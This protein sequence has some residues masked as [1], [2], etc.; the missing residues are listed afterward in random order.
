MPIKLDD[1]NPSVALN[2]LLYE[3]LGKFV[4]NEGND[5]DSLFRFPL[6]VKKIDMTIASDTKQATGISIFSKIDFLCLDETKDM[7]GHAS[8]C[9]SRDPPHS[10]SFPPMLKAVTFWNIPFIRT[11]PLRWLNDKSSCSRKCRSPSND[12]IGPVKLLCENLRTS[13][14]V[15]FP[16]EAGM[17]PV[18]LFQDKSMY[19]KLS[20]SPKVLGISPDSL[21]DA[22]DNFESCFALPQ[23]VVHLDC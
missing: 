14:L 15:I 20:K 22:S 19:S 8:K 7:T 10:P 16:M 1:E 12:G 21:F 18:K 2:R 6:Q 23:E 4:P 9:N 13:R 17:I 11:S 3:K 5:R